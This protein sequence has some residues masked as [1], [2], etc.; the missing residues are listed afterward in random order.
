MTNA[1]NA[2]QYSWKYLV[3]SIAVTDLADLESNGA[4]PSDW[5]FAI[6]NGNTLYDEVGSSWRERSDNTVYVCHK[7]AP[8][9]KYRWL[10]PDTIVQIYKVS[11]Q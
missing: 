7:D 9:S 11:A 2:T 4:I 5:K 8:E 10:H 6:K 1:T 3:C